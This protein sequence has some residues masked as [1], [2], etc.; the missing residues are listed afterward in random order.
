MSDEYTAQTYF[1]SWETDNKRGHSIHEFK[2]EISSLEAMRYMMKSVMEEF[3]GAMKG[4]LT[5]TQFNK[6]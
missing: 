5:A 2:E 6:V 3:E 4:V 1:M